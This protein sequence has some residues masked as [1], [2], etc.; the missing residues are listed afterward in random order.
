MVIGRHDLWQASVPHA[1]AVHRRL[2]R[3]TGRALLVVPTG[4]RNEEAV[5]GRRLDEPPVRR[6]GRDRRALP[7]RGVLVAAHRTGPVDGTPGAVPVQRQGVRGIVRGGGGVQRPERAAPAGRCRSRSR[8]R[9]RRDV[10]AVGR[11]RRRERDRSPPVDCA[12]V[13]QPYGQ[14]HRRFRGSGAGPRRSDQS[15][16]RRSAV[17]SARPRAGALRAPA[18]QPAVQR[19]VRHQLVGPDAVVRGHLGSAADRLERVGAPVIGRT[20]EDV[21]PV[22]VLP[23]ARERSRPHWTGA[24]R[25]GVRGRHP[26][27]PVLGRYVQDRQLLD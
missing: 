6:A 18:H 1:I 20:V 8:A 10:P 25:Q 13:G 5:R 23:E 17:H 26:G 24:G 11:Q 19:R 2:G 12:G 4:G 16:Q 27:P 3:G 9:G 15:G 7:V 14:R 22:A 21:R